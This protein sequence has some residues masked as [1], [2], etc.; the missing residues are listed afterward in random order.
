MFDILD[1]VT[2][3]RTLASRTARNEVTSTTDQCTNEGRLVRGHGTLL[4][5]KGD[6]EDASNELDNGRYRLHFLDER[7]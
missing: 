5:V 2:G 1:Y 6:I 4:R 7:P 3:A